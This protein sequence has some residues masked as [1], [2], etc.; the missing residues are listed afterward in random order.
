M[1]SVNEL[2]WDDTVLP[3]QLD[4][5]DVRGRVARLDGSL[6]AMLEQHAYPDPLRALVAEAVLLTALIGQT[7]KHGWR[8]SVQVHGDGPVRMVMADYYAPAEPGQAARMRAYASFNRDTIDQGANAYAQLGKGTFGVMIDQGQGTAPYQ[9]ITPLVGTTLADCAETYFAQSEQ[10]P[11]RFA[12][13]V[14][15]LGDVTR[16]GGLMLQHMPKGAPVVQGDGGSGQDGLL[17]PDD[18]VAGDDA[19]NWTRATML[20]QT[21]TP[22]ELSGPAVTP[23][24]LLVRLFHE[25]LP[26]VFDAQPV[27]FGCSCSDAAVRQSLSIYSAKDIATMTTAHGVV[28][29]DCHFC[30]SHYELDPASLGFEA[31][32]TPG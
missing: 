29:A 20:L 6:V 21:V 26:R 22:D 15:A 2:I 25:E 32:D 10:L 8:F 9:G 24:Q 7:M 3:F 28:T 16:A 23:D 27:R 12:L 1:A 5:A 18:L 13:T 30:G 19:E 31:T 17:A 11:T 14:Q 4:R